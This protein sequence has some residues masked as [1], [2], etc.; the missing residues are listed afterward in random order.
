[1]IQPAVTQSCFQVFPEDDS[2]VEDD[3]EFM[4]ILTST[5]RAVLIPDNTAAVTVL[6]NDGKNAHALGI[7]AVYSV[8]YK[9][10]LL[11]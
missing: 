6:N 2:I 1:M 11:T 8:G 7:M 4:I 10:P 9:Y 5:D 3:E